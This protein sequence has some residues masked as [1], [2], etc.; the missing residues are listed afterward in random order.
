MFNK[1]YSRKKLSF[2]NPKLID[3]Y[4]SNK[5]SVIGQSINYSIMLLLVKFQINL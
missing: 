1:N 3:K 5:Y 2:I 4:L